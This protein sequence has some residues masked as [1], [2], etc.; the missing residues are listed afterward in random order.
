MVIDM[1]LYWQLKMQRQIEQLS[2]ETKVLKQSANEQALLI[3][4][5]IKSIN[6]ILIKIGVEK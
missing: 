5:L 3:E 6:I 2:V 1:K 4:Q